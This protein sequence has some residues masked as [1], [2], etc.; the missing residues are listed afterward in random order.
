MRHRHLSG[1]P[2]YRLRL[3]QPLSLFTPPLRRL[4]RTRRKSYCNVELV[5]SHRR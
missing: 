3:Q 4:T 2:P 5:F 1:A